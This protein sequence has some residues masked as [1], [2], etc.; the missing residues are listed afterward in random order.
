EAKDVGP[1]QVELR[2]GEETT[3]PDSKIKIRFLSVDNDSR[4]P[5]GVNCIW[6]GSVGVS[7]LLSAPDA[8]DERVKLNTAVEPQS[9]SYKGHSLRIESVSPPR[10]EG[11]KITPEDYRITLAVCA[12]KSGA[13]K[14]G[15]VSDPA[16]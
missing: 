4:C 16:S 15:D 11:K 3:L 8:E 7:L 2:V 5:Q 10:V 12:E 13:H 6:A 9:V 14:T 1:R